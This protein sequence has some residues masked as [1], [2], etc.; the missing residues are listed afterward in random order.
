MTLIN[1]F[2]GTRDP[3]YGRAILK[4]FQ[5]IE[6]YLPLTVSAIPGQT[7]IPGYNLVKGLESR[8][9]NPRRNQVHLKSLLNQL[10]SR[11]QNLEGQKSFILTE[12]D[13]YDTNL[14]WCLGAVYGDRKGGSQ[15]IMSI[16]R[17]NNART[18]AHVATHEF[19]HM[20]GAASQGRRNTVSNLGSHC[21][22]LCVMQQKLF[23][24][25]IEAL[26]GR[27]V[28]K[29]DKFCYDCQT[30]LRY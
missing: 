10:L 30:E 13:L 25:E 20:F 9:Y 14:N 6:K 28:N 24:P 12:A 22:N 2:D 15:L 4:S 5:E 19:G 18:L 1:F 7:D 23:V 11:N 3:K 16:N 27:L 26:A 8:A 17:I 21:T 29:K